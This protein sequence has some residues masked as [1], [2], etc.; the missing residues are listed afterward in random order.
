MAKII[1]IDN[2]PCSIWIKINSGT[3]CQFRIIAEDLKPNSKYA[4]RTINVDGIREIYLSFP[5]TPKK[6]KLSIFCLSNRSQ[7][8]DASIEKRPLTTYE[9]WIDTNTKQFLQLA[10]PFSQICGF[11]PP[12]VLGRVFQ[13]KNKQFNIKYFPDIKDYMTGKYMNTPSRIGHNTGIIEVAA[14][15]FIPYTI[16]MRMMILLHEFSHKWKNPQINLPI[17]SETGADVNAL[18]IYLGMGFSKVDAIFVYANVFLK[19]QSPGNQERMRKIM[20]YIQGFENEEYAKR[21]S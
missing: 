10:I 8:F 12:S 11:E 15:K 7:V 20:N 13:S 21:I 16:P 4:D 17:S 9:I 1:D 18:Y 3:K 6:L 14:N 5:V 2:E 19:S